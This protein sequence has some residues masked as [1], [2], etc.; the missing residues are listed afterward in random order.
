[1]TEKKINVTNLIQK[2]SSNVIW[3]NSGDSKLLVE[4]S[5]KEGSKSMVLD[6]GYGIIL[7][8][9]RIL[10]EVFISILPTNLDNLFLQTQNLSKA[11][12]L[13][14]TVGSNVKNTWLNALNLEIHGQVS[15][16]HR[17]NK[18][19]SSDNKRSSIRVRLEKLGVPIR[20]KSI[21]RVAPAK[22]LV[23]KLSSLSQR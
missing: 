21:I 15:T 8:K 20:K 5:W 14:F 4:I 10:Y 23:L 19:L 1:M 12:V 16:T 3:V 7:G 2:N 17:Q 13:C 6:P 11:C 22:G 9:R 18:S